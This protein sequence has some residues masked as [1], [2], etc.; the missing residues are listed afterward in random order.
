[1][2]IRS[3]IAMSLVAGMVA[4]LAGTSNAGI[5]AGTNTVTITNPSFEDDDLGGQGSAGQYAGVPTG[6]VAAGGASVL[7][8][9]EDRV[10]CPDTPYGVAMVDVYAIGQKLGQSIG[11]GLGL[12]GRLLDVSYIVGRRTNDG[13]D[14]RHNVMIMAGS[15]STFDGGVVLATATYDTDLP[16]YEPGS[17]V[18]AFNTVN[19]SLDASG[20][21]GSNTQLWLV[22]EN[23]VSSGTQLMIDNVAVSFVVKPGTLIYG[24]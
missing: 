15:A 10:Y 4:A 6:W 12:L 8:I 13:L 2:K 19:L 3:T 1:M 18:G 22:F 7:A 5:N 20:D 11:T 16:Y 21:V 9:G 14:T 23:N 24:K 17:A